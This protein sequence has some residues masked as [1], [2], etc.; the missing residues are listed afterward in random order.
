MFL[1]VRGIVVPNQESERSCF[2]VLGVSLYQA[3]KVSDHVFVCQSGNL[4][5]LKI[6]E[7]RVHSSHR[8][9]DSCF[10]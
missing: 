2:C 4:K 7:N 1:C 10:D 5:Q 6:N 9:R 3:R 8:G